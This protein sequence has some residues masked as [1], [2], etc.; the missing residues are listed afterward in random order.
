MCLAY[1][2]VE[3]SRALLARGIV[4]KCQR[5]AAGD[6]VSTN[7]AAHLVGTSRAAI[8]GWIDKGR[9]IGVR[10]AGRGYRVPEWQFEPRMWDALACLPAAL[11][12]TEGW[13]LLT[14]LETPL[15]A[16]QGATPR[17]AIER[18]QVELVLNLAAHMGK[19]RGL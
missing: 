10:Q 5:L 15:G 2:S 8:I 13:A 3:E 1:V 11:G 7:E 4:A 6:M 19:L 14:F 17:A 12:T 18:G 9:C 16:L